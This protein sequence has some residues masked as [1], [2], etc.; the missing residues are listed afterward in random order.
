MDK[1]EQ[2]FVMKKLTRELKAYLETHDVKI[3][4]DKKFQCINPAHEDKDPSCSIG[5]AY[6]GTIF[7]CFGCGVAGTIFTAAH[8]LEG[9]PIHGPEFFTVTL[10]SLCEKYNI[11]YEPRELNEDEKAAILLRNACADASQVISNFVLRD[12]DK[13]V[14][15]IKIIKDREITR[16]SVQEFG[17]GA[18]PSVEEYK[19]IM[20]AK[21][22]DEDYLIRNELLDSEK[23][24]DKIFAPNKIILTVCDTVDRPIGFVSRMAD[25]KEGCGYAKYVNSTTSP[26]YKKADTLFGFNLAR[27]DIKKK[28]LYIVE[29]Y[30]DVV[31]LRQA[32]IKNVAGLGSAAFN[33]EVLNILDEGPIRKRKVKDGSGGIKNLIL[34]FDG[35]KGGI[36]CTRRALEE[37]SRRSDIS[38]KVKQLPEYLGKDPDEIIRKH[39]RKAFESIEAYTAFKWLL[40]FRDRAEEPEDVFIKRVCKTIAGNDSPIE[41]R[42]K[43]RDLSELIKDFTLDDIMKQIETERGNSDSKMNAKMEMILDKMNR[44]RR[45]AV[46]VDLINLVNKAYNELREIEKEHRKKKE[47][48]QIECVKM[49]KVVREDFERNT[50]EINGFILSKNFSK[51]S[52]ALDGFPNKECLVTIAGDPNTG[53]STWVRE[54]SW[55]IAKHNSDAI[56][57][58]MSIDDSAR[59]VL[60]ALVAREGD[61][62]RRYV[63]KY[64]FHFSEDKGKLGE[65]TE[66]KKDRVDEAWESVIKQCNKNYIIFDSTQGSTVMHLKDHI[67]YMRNNFS[68]KKPILFLDNFH[69]LRSTDSLAMREKFVEFSQ[70]IK[71]ITQMEDVPV[72]MT[73]ELRKHGGGWPTLEDIGETGK[74]SFDSKIILLMYQD[75]HHHPDTP[76]RWLRDKELDANH[77]VPE[78]PYLEV[79]VAKNKHT[80]KKPRLSY[81]FETD[82]SLLREVENEEVSERYKLKNN[83]H[84]QF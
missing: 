24:H 50:D 12:W 69:K 60:Q 4:I 73:A 7:H 8:F 17:I 28:P 52:K 44:E 48:P 71:D 27:R 13:D 63:Y 84:N 81:R 11:P 3:G 51:V 25:W 49:A 18:I 1:T 59:D 16:E 32:G 20:I 41:R 35:D 61:I 29:G 57:G 82:K 68:G 62:S 10:V 58:Y 75:M 67:D 78:M 36:E 21:G 83:P 53:K 5:G 79:Q 23:K 26:I 14:P 39:G 9:L 43:G 80:E 19:E 33:T 15:H 37:L 54:I 64:G 47:D 42:S 70:V 34:A 74:M 22:W 46:G 66:E 76:V 40:Q 2:D 65:R 45:S 72:V 38:V 30:I 55:D 77:D 6:E 56:V 31:S